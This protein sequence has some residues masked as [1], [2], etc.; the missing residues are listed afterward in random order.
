MRGVNIL[1]NTEAVAV[2]RSAEDDGFF[3]SGRRYGGRNK[4]KR[5]NELKNT[6]QGGRNTYVRFFNT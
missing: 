2:S 4:C 1:Q 3:V 5:R 6:Q